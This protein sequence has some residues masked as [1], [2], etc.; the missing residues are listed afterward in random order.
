MP[1]PVPSSAFNEAEKMIYCRKRIIDTLYNIDPLKYQLA[2]GD[3]KEISL[4]GEEICCQMENHVI[5]IVRSEV[6]KN[7]WEHRT[8]IPSYF[9]YK[10]WKEFTNP[11]FKNGIPVGAIDY[12]VDSVV[13]VLETK[14]GRVP[15][16][17]V[18]KDGVAKLY[19]VNE[20]DQ[21]C[22][23]KAWEQLNEF[24][25]LFEEE[26]NTHSDIKFAPMC[27]HLKWFNA[28]IKLQ[29]MSFVSQFVEKK[30]NPRICAYQY[31]P[32]TA[33]LRYRITNDGV[34]ANAQWIPVS[35]WKEKQ[36]YDASG[37]PTG[38]CWSTLES[39]LSG[40]HPYKLV[41]YSKTLESAFNRT[42]SR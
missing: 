14:A 10:I 22:T 26:F 17:A 34:R 1:K 31:D 39:A 4:V 41:P 30:Y 18:D 3:I 12:G 29:S 16:V 40:Q 21:S 23:C 13:G 15:K 38:E 24:K 35:G 5:L 27:K 28:A 7:F 32:R 33:T 19:Y 11:A 37:M 9:D 25:D 8:R 42:G 2:P 20:E 36:V 6:V